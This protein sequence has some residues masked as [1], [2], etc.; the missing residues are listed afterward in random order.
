MLETFRG[1]IFFIATLAT[2][3]EDRK[4]VVAP[5]DDAAFVAQASSGGM[6]EVELGKLAA[7]RA[8]REDVKNL[9][10]KL[11]EDHAKANEELKAAAKQAG[12]SVP[13]KLNDE[14]QR[15]VDHFKDYKGADFDKDYLKHMREDH[16]KDVVEFT[17]ASK[18]ARSPQIKEFAS[19][20]LPI[21]QEHLELIKK[22]QKE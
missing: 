14:H 19:K 22:L 9:A 17:R 21:I 10:R 6:H 18:E 13:D 15:H 3:G 4:P 1:A 20:T 11:V 16:E 8:R 2:S 12:L 5:F 7:M